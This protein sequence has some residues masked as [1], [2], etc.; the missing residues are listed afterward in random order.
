MSEHT[1][2]QLPWGI[3]TG[4][5]PTKIVMNM[6]EKGMRKEKI[7]KSLK[8]DYLIRN[9]KIELMMSIV[10]RE[11]EIINRYTKKD[12]SLYISIPFCPTRCIYCSFTSFPIKNWESYTNKY[13][14]ALIKEIEEVSKIMKNK[15]LRTI[16]I[17]GGTPTALTSEQLNKILNAI[18]TNFD[19]KYLDEYTV[20]AGRPDS[21][22]LD[23]LKVIKSYGVDRISINPQTM[24]NK[25][26]D[27]IGRKHSVQDII[28]K[29]KLARHVGFDNINMDLIIGLPNEDVEDL[30]RTLTHIK[31][32]NPESITVHA[33]AVKRA[34]RLKEEINS[35][36]QL[37]V[38]ETERMQESTVKFAKDN[39]YKPYY[40]YRQKNIAGNLENIG[41][42]KEKKLSIYNV[43][44]MEEKQSIIALGAG[45]VTKLVDGNKINRIENVKNV[46]D[47]IERFDEM[48]ERK[49]NNINKK[50]LDK[51]KFS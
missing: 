35:G 27:K 33:L 49:Y 2:K 34:S 41:Y 39:N 45:G 44:I 23:K 12:Y 30:N 50:P 40:M 15:Q 21:I 11:F 24:N 38:Q 9:D 5:R 17:G 6:F 25:T 18:E 46:V 14:E 36:Y 29:Y 22:T 47:Y 8:G 1:G 43:L 26:L 31:E 20:E 51:S 32:L 42:A 10:E 4:I 48:I 13:V 3:L 19:L 7:K 16:Y 28:D 37:Q